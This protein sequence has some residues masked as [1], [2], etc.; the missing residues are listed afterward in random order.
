VD[1]FVKQLV[2][3]LKMADYGVKVQ[4]LDVVTKLYQTEGKMTGD[5]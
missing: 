4:I 1:H 3:I 5:F 2:G